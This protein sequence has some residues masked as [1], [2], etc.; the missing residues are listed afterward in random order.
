ME[1]YID[2]ADLD[3]IKEYAAL[4]L[5]AGVT[6][7]P[8]FFY[9]DG[10]N[11]SVSRV[12]DIAAVFPGCIHLEAMGTCCDEIL[13]EARRNH[14]LC[15]R[16]V[17]KI[18]IS[19]EGLKA[20]HL[21]KREGIRTNVHLIFSVNQ[22]VLAAEAGADFIC[23]LIGRLND[24]DGGGL[25]MIRDIV[26]V[27]K[28]YGYPTIVMASSIRGSEDVTG[29][30]L[31]GVDAVTIP[32]KVIEHMFSHPL[33]DI[34]I[35]Q[36]QHDIAMNGCVQEVMK[37]GTDMPL[38]NEQ[39]SLLEALVEMSEKKIGLGVIVDGHGVL[40]GVITD[41]DI[42]RYLQNSAHDVHK[43]IG[44]LMNRTPVTVAAD[45]PLY[46]ALRMMEERRITQLVITRDGNQPIGYLNLHDVLQLRN[47]NDRAGE[48]RPQVNEATA[49][50][51]ALA[52]VA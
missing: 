4:S 16:A 31:C 44:D 23:P 52:V 21:L 20:V 43:A 29:S 6:T 12:R 39:C 35:E 49:R 48:A 25:T 3:V 14:R 38:L 15:D 46:R 50:S 18:P 41:G 10:V 7:T 30:L 36:F 26:S 9:R 8:T 34:G 17:S 47:R 37:K 2:S 45:L 51:A 42:R 1:F 28:R 24:V 22:A 33:T 19:K 27:I 32:P 5:F 11:N 40:A 13:K